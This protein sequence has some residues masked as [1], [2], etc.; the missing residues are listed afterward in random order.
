MEWCKIQ[1]FH[2]KFLSEGFQGVLEKIG[3][4]GVRV[5]L[6]PITAP[7]PSR[8]TS[9]YNLNSLFKLKCFQTVMNKS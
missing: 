9:K 2:A 3:F 6:K 1:K 8:M 5:T 7:F 4:K